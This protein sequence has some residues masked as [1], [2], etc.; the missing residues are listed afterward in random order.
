MDIQELTTIT[1]TSSNLGTEVNVVQMGTFYVYVEKNNLSSMVSISPVA[2]GILILYIRKIS[3][4]F[5]CT[6]AL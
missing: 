6:K 2:I 3:F 4:F 1:T 5:F